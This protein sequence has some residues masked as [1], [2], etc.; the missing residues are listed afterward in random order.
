[1]H[2]DASLSI[3]YASVPGMPYNSLSELP[4]EQVD[5]CSTH[6]KHAFLR[7]FNNAPKEYDV[8]EQEA[9][10]RGPDHCED[11]MVVEPHDQTRMIPFARGSSPARSAPSTSRGVAG[12]ALRRVGAASSTAPRL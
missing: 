1:L 5:Q 8:D 12:N 7:A 6:Q 3:G 2:D 10:I 9:G 11:P 4:R